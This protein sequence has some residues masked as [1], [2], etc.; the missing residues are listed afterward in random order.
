MRKCFL[1]LILFFQFL[2]AAHAYIDPA[3]GSMLLSLVISVF[4][5]IFFLFNGLI[6][7]IKTFFKADKGLSFNTFPY[8]IYSE[9]KQYFNVFKPIV[10]EFEKRQIELVYYTSSKDDPIF[11]YEYKFIKP[12]FIGQGMKA[13][14]KLAFLKADICLMTTP[15]L[16]VLHLKRS[17]FTKHYIHI[18]HAVASS[19]NYRLFSL[20]YY[21]SVLCD[22]E[23]Q[24]PL[25][26]ELE[27]KRNLPPKD[28][29]VV[30]CTYMDV[31]ADKI[32]TLPPKNSDFTILVAPSW[33]ESGIL[34]KYGEVFI[35]NLINSKYKIIIRP[36]PQTLISEKDVVD[37]LIS[38]Y[39][40]AENLSWNF[41]V[42]NLN[43]LSFA[44]VL[45]SDFSGVMFDYAFL[46]NKPF[47]Y[48]NKEVNREI[49]DI[50]DIEG[51]IW[52]DK[53][54]KDIG[55]ELLPSDMDNIIQIIENLSQDDEIQNRIS[56]AKDVAWQH[57][58]ESGIRAVEF[59]IRKYEE[60]KNV[61]KSL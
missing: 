30:G 55:V 38:K 29:E 28:L 56:N 6:I 7:K 54:I 51:E 1:F 36:H 34:R 45:I 25:I 32:K 33:G 59:M 40:G 20:D 43:V 11:S 27:R 57:R 15:H 23:F 8:V 14:S 12:E 4:A 60:L 46:F 17:K 42:E 53:A 58:G 47:L 48:L 35:D 5:T 13:Y 41:D 21:D 31:L 19:M 44:D 10:D 61:G 37:K 18:F 3:T 22:G 2:P 39:K 16:D 26:R 9:G 50:S 49:Y 24:I 52:R